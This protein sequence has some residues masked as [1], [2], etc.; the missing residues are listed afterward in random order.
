MGLD[1]TAYRQIKKIDCVFDEGGEPIDPN[2]R[3]PIECDY[4][5]AY[6]NPDFPGRAD[7]LEDR[8]IYSYEDA[9][10][11]FSGGYGR[12]SM[13]R[14]MLA[15]LA[16]Y[17]PIFVDRFGTG[18]TELRHD[19][20]AWRATSGPFWEL[21]CFSDCEGVIGAAVSAKLAQDF[22]Q[23]DEQAKADESFYA[24]YS[25]WRAAFEMAAQNG[26]VQFH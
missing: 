7:D 6:I 2:T 15:K 4:L 23:F 16:G 17:Q 12:Y 9:D 14:E 24:I 11:A 20:A 1:A 26:C 13:W 8:A 3:E 5:R 19:E 10:E 22:A 18:R 21:I 25:K